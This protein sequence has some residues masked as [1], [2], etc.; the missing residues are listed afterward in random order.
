MGIAVELEAT[1]GR[2]RDVG[3]AYITEIGTGTD[4]WK[5]GKAKDY[6]ARVKAHRTMSVERL[7]LY[8]EIE[9]EYYGEIET[10][11]K[12]LLLGYRWTEGEGTEIYR[13][14]RSVIDAAVAS[15]RNRA[16]LMPRL[17][18]ARALATQV[19]N[20]TVLT[21]DEAIRE[22][23]RRRLRVRQIEWAAHHEGEELDAEIQLIMGAAEE[24]T[25]VATF[26]SGTTR[27]FDEAAF[28][29]DH[30]K[31]HEAYKFTRPTRPFNI[32]W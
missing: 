2:Q 12:H 15:A 29:L 16:F 30:E 9:T 8:A 26:R 18:D 6:A 13:A 11:L 3:C 19:S 10:Y 17:V 25:G 32:Q 7:T 1:A 21:P 28:R 27:R 23:H 31:L 22:L 4:L 5:A 14:D 24:L 20:G